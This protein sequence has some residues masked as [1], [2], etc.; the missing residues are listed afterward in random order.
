MMG[1]FFTAL[2]GILHL[3]FTIYIWVV[4]ARVVISWLQVNPYNAV[5]QF[6]YRSTEPVL[7]RIRRYIPPIAGL[8][9]SPV[10][11]IF[12]IMFLDRFLVGT[13]HQMFVY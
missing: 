8:D 5:V 7:M 4:I 12:A 3:F 1:N 10:I 6:I 13:L 2:A 9:L 11:L